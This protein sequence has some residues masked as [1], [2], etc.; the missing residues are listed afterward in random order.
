[1]QGASHVIIVEGEMD[2]L[3]IEEATGVT[4]VLSI[5]SGAA[6][7]TPQ[8]LQDLLQ[9][10]QKPVKPQRQQT[11]S[12][13]SNST[14]S[15]DRKFAYV[16]RAADLLRTVEQITIAVDGDAAGFFTACELARRLGPDRCMYLPW[17]A[18]VLWGKDALQHVAHIAQQQFGVV[19]DTAAGS[20]CKDANDMLMVYGGQFLKLYLENAATPFTNVLQH[21]QGKA[22]GVNSTQQHLSQAVPVSTSVPA[23]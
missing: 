10:Q 2:K 16:H 11:H 7:Y 17:P 14:L 4:A 5:P 19:V 13:S 22:V 23:W 12:I 15:L 20:G 6:P 9:S 8:Q 18:A 1:M 21:V 3:A